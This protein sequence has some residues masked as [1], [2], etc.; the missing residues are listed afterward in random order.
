MTSR[1]DGDSIVFRHAPLEKFH[2]FTHPAS[3]PVNSRRWCESNASA[4]IASP[5]C[6]L[7]NLH[8]HTHTHSI[9]SQSARA[10]VRASCRGRGPV[11]DVQPPRQEPD[12]SH[13]QHCGAGFDVEG[14]A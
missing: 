14:D 6:A 3:E 9:S 10:R 13:R 12:N 7:V 5:P 2:A 4:V 8:T 11:A 1:E